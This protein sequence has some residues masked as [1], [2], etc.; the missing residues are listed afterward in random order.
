[1]F[2]DRLSQM[3]KISHR[4]IS[5]LLLASM[6]FAMPA[7]HAQTSGSFSLFGSPACSEW[8]GMTPEARLTWA[9]AYLSTISKAYLEIRGAAARQSKGAED[10]DKAV[11]G[12]D[13]HCSSHPQAQAS[14]GIAP[15][16]N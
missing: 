12:I 5:L 3:K 7:V 9:R 14:D 16:L 1:M 13:Q 10:A 6:S 11:Q 2:A 8:T 15:F 4:V